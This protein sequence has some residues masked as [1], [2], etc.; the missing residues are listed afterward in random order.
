MEYHVVEIFDKELLDNERILW[1]GQPYPWSIFNRMDFFII[2]FSLIF[3]G[4]ACI[5]GL[6]FLRPGGPFSIIGLFLLII[7]GYFVIGRFFYK[8]W[9][10][11]RTY[12][13]VTNKRILIK[14]H[15]LMKKSQ[16]AY[17][18]TLPAINKTIGFGKRGTLTFGNRPFYNSMYANTGL[19]FLMGFYGEDVPSFY[20]IEDVETV[21]RLVNTLRLGKE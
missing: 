14:T 5:M 2:P 7:A 6:L 17:I 11:K 10:K 1:A 4:I 8:F 19:D 16:V 15:T 20:D 3:G 13:A 18:D 9:K 12:Y 21:Y